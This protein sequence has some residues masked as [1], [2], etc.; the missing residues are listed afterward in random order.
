MWGL[1]RHQLLISIVVGLTIFLNLGS[2]R[3]WDRDEPR[4]AGCAV[5]MLER[6]DWV[7]PV[8]NAELRGHKPVLLYWFM[9]SAYWMFGVN[10]FAARFWSAVLALGT[11]L[12]TYHIGRRMFNATVG[13]WAGIILASNMVFDMAGRAAT[14]DSVLIFFTTLATMIYVFAAFRDDAEQTLGENGGGA[15]QPRDWFPLS[16]RTAALMY[17]VM[18]IAII[19]KGPVGLVLPTAVIGMFLLIQTLPKREPVEP[20]TTWFARLRSAVRV[21]GPRH[22]LQT[23]WRMRPITALATSL[24]VAAPWYLWVGLRTN[25][26]FLRAF[27]LEH[28]F[29]RAT[30]PMEGHSGPFMLFYVAAILVGFFPWSVFAGPIVWEITAKLRRGDRW[31]AGY[32][33]GACWVGVYLVMFSCASTKLPSYITPCYPALALL[34]GVFVYRWTHG[35]SAVS[36]FW[37]SLSFATLGAVGV[38]IIVG[39]SIACHILLPGERIVP[40]IGL[41]PIAG[42]VLGYW[43][44]RQDR[45]RDAGV[46]FA[47]TAIAFVATFY[48]FTLVRV[49]QHRRSDVL[50]TAIKQNSGE[51]EIGAYGCLEGS[52]VFY[53]GRPIDELDLDQTLPQ[54]GPWKRKTRPSVTEFFG[55]GQDRFI[56]TTDR[57]WPELK[58]ILPNDVDVMAEC[59]YFLEK[60]KLLLVG[61]PSSNV[62]VAER[63]STDKAAKR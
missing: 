56:I 30:Q 57:R 21:F 61:R 50:L 31:Q 54:A 39:L 32:V 13:L 23:C 38:L 3:L 28:N 4:N 25:G 2:T 6:G 5:E 26:E 44:L 63:Q 19:A 46:A 49:D 20:A 24:A 7:V 55:D 43:L 22:F 12:F 62:Q 11:A 15:Q 29:G 10:E 41:I 17:G 33:F 35:D 36:R 34:T 59:P 14:P 48:G 9:M 27:L 60:D 16:W 52:W 51:P 58:K 37:S 42:A 47:V 45:M 53:S 1:V 8:F 18:G 40:W